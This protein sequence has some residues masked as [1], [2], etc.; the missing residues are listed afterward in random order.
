MSNLFS[1]MSLGNAASKNVLNSDTQLDPVSKLR[2]SN[3]MNLI[4]TDFEYGLQTTKW[5]TLELVNNIPTF[6]NRD[7]D[8]TIDI[9][10]VTTTAGS[11]D[12]TVTTPTAHGF[13]VGSAFIIVGL[14]ETTAEGSYVVLAVPSTTTFIYKARNIQKTTRSI[15]DL[16]TTFLYPARIF[17]GAQYNLDQ[18]VKMETDGAPQSQI[19]V[20]TT[21]PNNLKASTKM[22]LANSVGLK[23]IEFDAS[24]VD[25]RDTLTTVLTVA[26]DSNTGNPGYT[27]R[28]FN[29][30]D[31]QSR[32]TKFFES[33]NV[34][35][36][37]DTINIESHDFSNGD[38]V[39][40]V[41]PVG[42]TAVGGLTTNK[43]YNVIRVDGN[44]IQLS[45]ID[46]VYA[47]KAH[48]DK[49]VA[50]FRLDRSY[51]FTATTSTG[52]A[53]EHIRSF[54]ST[55]VITASNPLML[56]SFDLADMDRW[57]NPIVYRNRI[58]SGY[59]AAKDAG[60]YVFGIRVKQ[61]TNTASYLYA[62]L[63]Y[64]NIT[65]TP[66][67]ANDVSLTGVEL[68][69][70]V[71][72]TL[73]AGE[74]TNM[75]IAVY[76]SSSANIQKI[77]FKIPNDDTEYSIATVGGHTYIRN[78]DFIGPEIYQS[79]SYP[80]TRPYSTLYSLT[81]TTHYNYLTSAN[82]PYFGESITYF[83]NQLV[84]SS[85]VYNDLVMTGNFIA[86]GTGTYQFRTNPSVSTTH[87]LTMFHQS[88]YNTS[89]TWGVTNTTTPISINLTDGEIVPFVLYFR[90]ST[91]SGALVRF[92]YLTP[93][94]A[95]WRC[96]AIAHNWVY[97][98][99]NRHV[100][101]RFLY[102]ANSSVTS[103]PTFLTYSVTP[104]TQVPTSASD[105][106]RSNGIIIPYGYRT[107]MMS[108]R[109]SGSTLLFYGYFVTKDA[110]T[111]GFVTNIASS[112]SVYFMIGKN[113]VNLNSGIYDIN[114]ISTTYNIVLEANKRYPIV[115]YVTRSGSTANNVRLGYRIPG[116]ATVIYTPTFQAFTY[117]ESP[118]LDTEIYNV[119]S[120]A[121]NLTTTGTSTYG[122]HALMKAYILT[123]IS[124]PGASPLLTLNATTSNYTGG[125]GVSDKITIFAGES[126]TTTGFATYAIL[127][128]QNNVSKT[129]Y[130]YNYVRLNPIIGTT[131]T[132]ISIARTAGG[133]A[134][135]IQ[136]S[137]L[138]TLCWVVPT[139]QFTDYD[140][141]YVP[142][143][144]L[145]N[146]VAVQ[147]SNV[148][149]TAPGG[150]TNLTTYYAQVITN[151]FFRLKTGTGV[152]AAEV[153]ITS[154]GTG[155]KS[156]I[157]TFS[158]QYAN[159]I[160]AV[161]HGLVNTAQVIYGN[162]G[163][164]SVPGLT[165]GNIY[166][167]HNATQDRFGLSTTKGT[168]TA[169][170]F[171]GTSTGAQLITSTERSTDGNYVIALSESKTIFKLQAPF[172]IPIKSITFNPVTA[173]DLK[174]NIM[175]FASHG[176]ST[177]SRVV[178]NAN[179][180]TSIGGLTTNQNYYVIRIDLNVFR[181]ALSYSDAINNIPL[182][183]SSLGTG[184]NHI[185]Q[186]PSICGEIESSSNVV[187][188][189][190]CNIVNTP[191]EDL[192]TSKRVGDYIYIQ[193][194]NTI[195]YSA[196][197]VDLP[198]DTI[199]LNSNHGLTNGDSI[200]F[201]AIGSSNITGL[202]EGG[203]YYIT[204]GTASN[205]IVLY[206]TT[207][208][209]LGSTNRID[210]TS[211]TNITF[212]RFA[213]NYIG[214]VFRSRVKEI[215][216]S[217]YSQ[218]DDLPAF[219]TTTGRFISSTFLLP[220]NDGSSMHRPYDGGVMLIPSNNPNASIVRQT[221]KYF[222]Y[223]SGKGIQV[224]KAV[225][226]SAPVELQKYF[227]N[228]GTTAY[229]IT[230][231]P[232]RLTNGV[233]ITIDNV[234]SASANIWN[235][236]FI[237][238]NIIDDVTFTI[239]LPSTP[240]DFIAGGYPS[241]HVNS[242]A[243]SVLRAGLFDDQNG[244]FFEYDGT[245]LY[246]CRRSSTQQ[247]PGTCTVEF[248]NS[249][250]VG[251]DT[252]FTTQLNEGDYIVIKGQSYKI[253]SIDSATDMYIQPAYRGISNTN[254]VI[255]RTIDTKVPQSEWN[256]DKFDGTGTSGYNLNI[257]KIQMIY[258]DYSWYG[259][260]S[261]RYGFKTG[262]GKIVY[263]H[264]LIH[265]NVQTEAYMRS[266]NLPGRYEITNT[267]VPTYVPA[268]MHWGTSV[269]MDG[270][271]D[272]DKAYWFTASG[273]NLQFAGTD[274]VTFTANTTSSGISTLSNFLAPGTSNYAFR[275]TCSNYNE[276]VGI[277]P[278]TVL[279]GTGLSNNT[280]T[281]GYAGRAQGATG[282]LYIDK[283]RSGTGL[284]AATISAGTGENIPSI[285]P[286]VS[287]RLAPSVDNGRAGLLGSREIINRMQLALKTVGILTTHDVEVL[288]ILN[289]FPFT[290]TWKSV[291]F[292]SLSQLLL[293]EKGDTI[294]GGTRI[295]TF[296]A[297]GGQT[298]SFGKR[299]ASSSDADL[300]RITDLGN[301]ILGGDG[302][303]PNGPD[304]LTI[305]VRL[306]DFSGI[307]TTTPFAIS[308]RVTWTESQA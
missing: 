34:D 264:K 102:S 48:P 174:R 287:I 1:L 130:I 157:I 273:N 17:Q 300:S 95:F 111:Y 2:V 86:K 98:T 57:I 208:D 192:L 19:V 301:S 169:V 84:S 206:P 198:T 71:S 307:S 274:P 92:E 217:K 272:D 213:K 56:T 37:T 289:A 125:L 215:K 28:P 162:N 304:L 201:Y 136:E 32:N 214:T 222:R 178:Y 257:H 110:G 131:S 305:A 148:S 210:I 250:V 117:M 220:R 267:D 280:F 36:G 159:T 49:Y 172:N 225:N 38:A 270:R 134:F 9:S 133:S 199:T 279:A 175:Y 233:E 229:C 76:D 266:G 33:A 240:E 59:F 146:N 55:P 193:N 93:L 90:Y 7:G 72:R 255:T 236:V 87:S 242:W 224:S 88:V 187:V 183:L 189:S 176:M 64:S 58:L 281:V 303:F 170:D 63:G 51:N 154:P 77:Y 14:Q 23:N 68:P 277:P 167:V 244:I 108:D 18:I 16:Y 283:G 248:G 186:F 151:D 308:G 196:T 103:I 62:W 237:V 302:T 246:A 164:T 212:A 218:I 44:N 256:L 75:L 100:G 249:L 195:T 293:H 194:D 123:G 168:I 52:A 78:S 156:F 70:E 114:N 185:I 252:N 275:M 171:T 4:D 291:Q 105:N 285:I 22:L 21:T 143:H 160:Y 161:N 20:E 126:N 268:L 6:F 122:Y 69:F 99:K 294:D 253:A 8:I 254:V 153:D 165:S 89:T 235:G 31:W 261:V 47:H 120:S 97:I 209:Q 140:S 239:N 50:G 278:N 107:N 25:P 142:D 96:T 40:Y 115:F 234:V 158:N 223:Q 39:M 141:I 30:Y 15:Y 138:D 297:S 207:G 298:D 132:N 54:N 106:T 182:I 202:T 43:L 190:G 41:S 129:D 211:A 282:Y 163:N 118:I 112:E 67:W 173:V 295:F 94:D 119:V 91:G 65:G 276:I 116:N 296:R 53:N 139:Y 232:H 101:M 135:R 292:P 177:G 85:W 228:A 238:Q 82:R 137:R 262:E 245:T 74:I 29:P 179:G 184:T 251:T 124:T 155:T 258:I 241:F 205:Q 35:T 204:V 128:S 286:L 260:G 24:L 180:N 188:V 231:F 150:L 12:V 147:F 13:I 5:E 226:F 200:R 45:S 60:T 299:I 259:A 243:N 221:R 27:S 11:Y 290:K 3:P 61:G 181:L 306:L 265:N 152:N 46:P 263:G 271:M 121:I 247:L 197:T 284:A 113:A 227:R 203:I 219:S 288:V 269:I 109:T 80:S 104:S 144:G 145:S 26:S 216:S 66:N 127:T 10:N 42:D 79:T 83:E 191:S 73:A 81:Y 149:G 166:Y 230:R